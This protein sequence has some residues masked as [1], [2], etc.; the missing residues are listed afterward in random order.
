MTREWP[1]APEKRGPGTPLRLIE[2]RRALPR[3]RSNWMCWTSTKTR[4]TGNTVCLRALFSQWY[5]LR[6]GVG[7]V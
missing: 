3:R 4:P 2:L 6:F 7:G 1:A 5:A